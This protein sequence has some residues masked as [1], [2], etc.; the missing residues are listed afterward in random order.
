MQMNTVPLTTELPKPHR[1]DLADKAPPG[2]D[3]I[4]EAKAYADRHVY[5]GKQRWRKDKAKRYGL[6]PL[7]A[8]A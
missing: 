3:A 7:E 6:M 4:A 8:A 2:P 1:D 5:I